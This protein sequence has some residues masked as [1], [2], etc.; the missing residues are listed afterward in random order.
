MAAAN[1]TM[2]LSHTGLGYPRFLVATTCAYAVCTL[3]QEVALALAA[4]LP[5]HRGTNSD[6][7]KRC[8]ED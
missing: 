3:D 7:C 2:T 4:T 6:R 8:E 5:R 1:D